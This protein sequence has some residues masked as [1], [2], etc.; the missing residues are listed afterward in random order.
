MIEEILLDEWAG[1]P[2]KLTK[3]QVLML[4]SQLKM[5]QR[6][7][8]I[9]FVFPQ[10]FFDVADN[11]LASPKDT[12]ITPEKLRGFVI[13]KTVNADYY[14]AAGQSKIMTRYNLP[15]NQPPII[16]PPPKPSRIIT[17]QEVIN[18]FYEV[19]DE[20]AA[21]GEMVKYVGSQLANEMAANRIMTFTAL[22]KLPEAVNKILNR[23]KT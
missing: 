4:I 16:T 14:F 20:G 3:E 5:Y 21:W 1:R 9:V 13:E 11:K 7:S 23:V 6:N 10:Q 15:V 17:N 19:Y 8:T 22:E 12:V 2:D 18:A